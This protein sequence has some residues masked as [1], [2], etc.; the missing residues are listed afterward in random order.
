M[1]TAIT[2]S[3][4][5][6][7][8]AKLEHLT[9]L[10]EDVE[11]GGSTNEAAISVLC[12]MYDDGLRIELRQLREFIE[13][14]LRGN[15]K[16]SEPVACGRRCA[17]AGCTQRAK[18]QAALCSEHAGIMCHALGGTG[19]VRFQRLAVDGPSSFTDLF[20]DAK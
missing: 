15:P 7:T 14:Y 10:A 19:T 13:K 3:E 1:N 20:T 2:A 17:C 6:I 5:L 16:V 11:R 12:D 18:A 4:L 9:V 8:V